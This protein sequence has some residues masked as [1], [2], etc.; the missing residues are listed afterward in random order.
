MH[1]VQCRGR[2]AWWGVHVWQ[3]DV[4][5]GVCLAGEAC[6]A[7]VHVWQGGGMHDMHGVRGRSDGHCSE[8]YKMEGKIIM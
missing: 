1:G 4:W 6:M 8:H 5:W 3:V 2:C 7:G